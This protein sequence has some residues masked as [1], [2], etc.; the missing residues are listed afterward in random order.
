MRIRT[1]ETA[2]PEQN[3][4]EIARGDRDD[5]RNAAFAQDIQHRHTGRALRLAVIRKAHGAV[6]QDIRIDVVTGIPMLGFF[7]RDEIERLL[8]GLHR[9]GIADET[10]S[11][12]HKLVLRV[13]PHGFVLCHFYRSPLF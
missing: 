12:F 3:A 7:G 9:A 10:R 2:A 6:A 5:I 4:A 1:N 13:F 11:L 8:L